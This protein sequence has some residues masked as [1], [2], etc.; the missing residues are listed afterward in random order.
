[1]S[2]PSRFLKLKM[3]APPVPKNSCHQTWPTIHH[4]P[5][6]HSINYPQET[7]PWRNETQNTGI[8]QNSRI[9]IHFYQ[10]NITLAE[11][12]R[13]NRYKE[14]KY[15]DEWFQIRIQFTFNFLC[16][17]PKILS[18]AIMSLIDNFVGLIFRWIGAVNVV[19]I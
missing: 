2:Q 13:K 15:L 14:I 8:F 3:V 9:L 17:Y 5:P 10:I 12:K 4:S 11:K 19:R 6:W 18:Q 1:M 7:L 16:E